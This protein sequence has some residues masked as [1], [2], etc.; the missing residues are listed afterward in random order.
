VPGRLSREKRN[1][2]AY[3]GIVK[4]FGE[5]GADFRRRALGE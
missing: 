5:K 2:Y 4:Q 3:A 1:G